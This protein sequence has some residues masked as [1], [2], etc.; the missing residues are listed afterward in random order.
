MCK[1]HWSAALGVAF[2]YIS[3]ILH[4][5]MGQNDFVILGG[6]I[7]KQPPADIE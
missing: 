5:A 3:I 7:L 1:F 4:P 6:E 2:D